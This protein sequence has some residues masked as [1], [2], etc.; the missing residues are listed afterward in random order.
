[1]FSAILK[2]PLVPKRSVE[3]WA[4]G[5]LAVVAMGFVGCAHHDVQREPIPV[6]AN[7]SVEVDRLQE[8]LYS[9]TAEQVDMLAPAHYTKAQNY[10]KSARVM[11]EKSR[12]GEK[13][14]DAVAWGQAYLKKA[15][16]IASQNQAQLTS[17]TEARQ[18]AINAQ[19]SQYLSKDMGRADG[20]F[21]RLARKFEAGNYSADPE[22]INYLQKLYMD[23]E[24]DSIKKQKLGDARTLIQK[25]KKNRAEKYVPSILQQAETSLLAAESIIDTDRSNTERIDK[26]AQEAARQARRVF[27]LNEVARQAEGRSP[28]EIAIALE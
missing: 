1:M 7:P 14:L 10:L 25:S 27:A 11:L 6:T 20:K 16:D 18:A 19:A 9:A 21:R 24:V 8:D 15:R 13:V 5:I 4:F 12:P 2:Q 26:A 23:A 3:K 17:V 22:D 28:E